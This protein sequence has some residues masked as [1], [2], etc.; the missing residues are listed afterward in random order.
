MGILDWWRDRQ[1]RSPDGPGAEAVQETVEHIVDTAN[2]RLR[3]APRY[4]QR[5]SPAVESALGYASQL[6]AAV[7][8]AREATAA[9]WTADPCM[10]AFFATPDD[11]V[12][13]FSRSIELRAFFNSNPLAEEVYAVI[14]M[15]VEERR[16]A[17]MA[18]EGSVIR[19]DVEQTTISFGD[20]R[21]RVLGLT[22]ADLREE[23]QA[24]IIDQLVLD[25]INQAAAMQDQREAAE[26]ERALLKARLR[27]LEREGAGMG[28]ALGRESL[29]ARSE[30]AK[31]QAELEE[32][33]RSLDAMGTGA[34]R[35]DEEL[36]RIVEALTDAPQRFYVTTRRVRLDRMNV[37][38][39]GDD[40]EAGEEIVFQCARIPGDPPETRA[41]VIARFPRA[42]MLPPRVL[43][44]EAVR[45]IV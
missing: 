32:N 11:I 26:Q 36:E 22:E 21:V 33:N 9:G 4:A 3:F 45:H 2:P 20:H 18:L 7:P 25:G 29:D 34:D 43:L 14:G 19:K 13:A 41:F 30:L 6:V 1:V 12:R 39:T 23:I 15:L 8:P 5:L 38:Q 27:L 44:T 35:L 42:D 31:V 37:V 17:G 28:A 10:R 24:R 16:I 40:P